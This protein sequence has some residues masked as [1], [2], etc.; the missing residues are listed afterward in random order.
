MSSKHKLL[1]RR[2]LNELNL[3]LGSYE[4]NL[5]GDFKQRYR[6]TM[7]YMNNLALWLTVKER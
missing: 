2:I 6:E 5:M 3:L 4:E 1:F 7:K